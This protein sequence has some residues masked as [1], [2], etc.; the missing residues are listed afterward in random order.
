MNAGRPFNPRVSWVVTPPAD[1]PAPQGPTRMVP[2]ADPDGRRRADLSSQLPGCDS[3]TRP[4]RRTFSRPPTLQLIRA[5]RCNPRVSWVVTPPAD[6][7]APQGPTRMV[8]PADPAGRRRADPTFWP[9]E[10]GKFGT[11]LPL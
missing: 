7:L 5:F 8:P 1:R 10:S 9:P 3:R 6:R 4:S 11:V 2:P